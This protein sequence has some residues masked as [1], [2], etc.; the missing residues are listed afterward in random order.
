MMGM[1]K[2]CSSKESTTVRAIFKKSVKHVIAAV[3]KEKPP[4]SHPKE[5]Y[6]ANILSNEQPL[7]GSLFGKGE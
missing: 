6:Q 2:T 4:R 7:T 5:L 1:E 3:N